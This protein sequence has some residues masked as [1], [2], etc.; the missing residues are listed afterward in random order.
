[1]YQLN[2]TASGALALTGA[3]VAQT[4]VAGWTLFAAGLATLSIARVLRMRHR[5]HTTS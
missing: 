4:W 5:E 2:S 3:A 1:M